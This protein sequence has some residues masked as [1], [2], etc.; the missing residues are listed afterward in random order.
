MNSSVGRLST[1]LM[2]PPNSL[3]LLNR[4]EGPRMISTLSTAASDGRVP[5]LL[6]I[7]DG[8][9]LRFTSSYS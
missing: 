2:T 8:R 6:C 4:P 9:P 1:M 7:G 5:N 3:V